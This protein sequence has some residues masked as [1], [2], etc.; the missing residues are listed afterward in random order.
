MAFF[1]IGKKSGATPAKPPMTTEAI[2]GSDETDG[3]E[4]SSSSMKPAKK[5]L[6]ARSAKAKVSGKAGKGGFGGAKAADGTRQTSHRPSG[7]LDI[8]TAVLAAAAIA[9]AAGC[10]LIAVDNLDGV[11][12]TTDEGNPFAVVSSN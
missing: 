5:G 2:G 10:V 7:D 12:G 3:G 11:E 8:Y 6:F 9:L 4:P 1:G